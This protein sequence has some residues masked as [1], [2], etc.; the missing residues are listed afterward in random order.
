MRKK[1]GK[2]RGRKVKVHL[3]P[4]L[5]FEGLMTKNERSNLVLRVL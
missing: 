4:H 2:R 1:G 5:G 3:G